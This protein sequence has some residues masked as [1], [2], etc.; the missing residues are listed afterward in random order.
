MPT[1]EQ[2][3][4]VPHFKERKRPGNGLTAFCDYPDQNLSYRLE[5]Q[6]G[7]GRCLPAAN[8]DPALVN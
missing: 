4:A 2:W 3:D 8:A 6:P 1:S 7:C 5:V